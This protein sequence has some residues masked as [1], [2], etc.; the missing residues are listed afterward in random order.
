MTSSIGWSGT[1]S[2]NG[3][4]QTPIGSSIVRQST[5]AITVEEAQ[6]INTNG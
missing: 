6:A 3:G 1:Y 5:L 4:P 2:V